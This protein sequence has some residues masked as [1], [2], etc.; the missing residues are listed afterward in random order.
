VKCYLHGIERAPFIVDLTSPEDITAKLAEG[1]RI[2]REIDEQLA[3]LD[4]L[5]RESREWRANVE[6]LASKV[7]EHA[8]PN[9]MVD[10]SAGSGG[11]MQASSNGNGRVRPMELVVEVV[12]REI[13][14]IRAMEVRAI[15]TQEGND[16]TPEQVSNALHYAATG[17]E[18]NLILR[19][20]GRGMYAPLAY[21]ESELTDPTALSATGSPTSPVEPANAP[22]GRENVS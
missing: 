7:P 6:F 8:R 16:L 17:A 5:R 22:P 13:R 4:D 11:F 10:P 3:G 1:Q 18:P 20:P 2:L 9:T 15:L 21:R 14:K 12:N 19:A